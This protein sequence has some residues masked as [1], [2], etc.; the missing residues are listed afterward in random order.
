MSKTDH[1]RHVGNE[2]CSASDVEVG[3]RSTTR[4]PTCV[5]I[6]NSN[7]DVDKHFRHPRRSH[8]PI[9]GL[10]APS[11]LHCRFRRIFDL[12]CRTQTISVIVGN[13][14]CSTSGCRSR[15]RFD[16]P[17]LPCRA[18]KR[19]RRKRLPRMAAIANLPPTARPIGANAC[20]RRRPPTGHRGA[21]ASVRHRPTPS[22]A[23][24]SVRR[25]PAPVTPR[26]AK[27]SA[28]T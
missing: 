16:K 26:S 20:V 10:Q 22:G 3:D 1:L 21:N 2:T 4:P 9:V 12:E 13:D 25:R 18:C 5:A 15:R 6:P 24:A 14:T 23:N 8:G 28:Q 11:P 19:K 17:P 7:V 27:A